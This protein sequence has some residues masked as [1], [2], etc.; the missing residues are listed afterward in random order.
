MLIV[1]SLHSSDSEARAIRERASGLWRDEAAQGQAINATDDAHARKKRKVDDLLQAGPIP[2]A[3]SASA[4]SATAAQSQDSRPVSGPG[5]RPTNSPQT[6]KA[7]PTG[8]SAGQGPPGQGP[9]TPLQSQGS[10]SSQTRQQANPQANPQRPSQP[11]Q[12]SSTQQRQSAP[13]SAADDVVI[14]DVETAPPTRLSNA[15]T[16]S[17]TPP[18]AAAAIDKN[19]KVV[20]RPAP[21]INVPSPGNGNATNHPPTQK[22]ARSVAAASSLV[23]LDSSLPSEIANVSPVVSGFPMHTADK[24]T[25]ESVSP[26]LTS[27]CGISLTSA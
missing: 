2:S 10:H 1:H 12:T 26:G 6:I 4:T 16:S 23:E 19:K 3:Q 14:A 25:L 18:S 17:G 13:T 22:S 21:L 5:G 11:R 8:Q 15:P 24:A 27:L 9:R 7:A 20:K